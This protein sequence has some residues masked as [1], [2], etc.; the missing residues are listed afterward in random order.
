MSAPTTA[1]DL[2]QIARLGE[3]I[4]ARRVAGVPRPDQSDHFVAIDVRSE[5]F[6]IDGDD[7]TA[8]RRLE[9]RHPDAEV[10]LCRVGP[11]P[12]YQMGAWRC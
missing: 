1:R 6:E 4:Y 10:W 8:M 5:D 12:A 9:E 2:D 11:N 3:A 7:F